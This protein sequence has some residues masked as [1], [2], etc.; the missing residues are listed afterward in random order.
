MAQGKGNG[1]AMLTEFTPGQVAVVVASD[2]A[3]MV[4]VLD[5]SEFNCAGCGLDC[6]WCRTVAGQVLELCCSAIAL[7]N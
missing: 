3:F 4:E 1:V 2:P 5:L 7:P 6:Y